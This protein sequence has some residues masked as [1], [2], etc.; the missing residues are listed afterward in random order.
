MCVKKGP[1]PGE[2]VGRVD[3]LNATPERLSDLVEEKYANIV[4]LEREVRELG[5]ANR[6]LK[7]YTRRPNLRFE[8]IPEADHGRT[9]ML[10]CLRSRTASWE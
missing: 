6:S 4:N 3:A 1:F 8:G 9:P 10:R 2:V 5:D 7:Q